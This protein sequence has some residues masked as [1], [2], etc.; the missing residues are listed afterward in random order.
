MNKDDEGTDWKPT[1]K[2][3]TR[4]ERPDVL[5]SQPISP[6]PDLSSAPGGK[7]PVGSAGLLAKLQSS[8]IERRAKVEMLKT[9]HE[10]ELNLAR[11]QIAEAV[12]VKKAEASGIAERILTQLDSDR[13][14]FLRTL[15][16][17]NTG[18]RQ[19]ALLEL[20]KQTATQLAE[21]QDQDMPEQLL[22]STIEGVIELDKRF[23]NKL[24]DEL[25]K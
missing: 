11:H 1:E 20:R 16:L 14:E 10:G 8:T 3:L 13:I 22:Q 4:H 18:E 5:S 25:D 7:M 19:Q 2:A 6:V 24:L 21:I 23:F 9:W 12:K 17:K 15:G